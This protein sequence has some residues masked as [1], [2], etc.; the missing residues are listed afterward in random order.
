MT[1]GYII[2][3]VDIFGLKFREFTFG[4]ADRYKKIARKCV[5]MDKAC[6][7]YFSGTDN[8]FVMNCYDFQ[9]LFISYIH[10]IIHS[11]S[12]CVQVKLS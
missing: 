1:T 4:G 8:M 3:R 11:L 2:T 6:H 5:D 9:I 10:F 12:F 7:T